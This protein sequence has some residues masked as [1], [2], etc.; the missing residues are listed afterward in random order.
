MK[1]NH[2]LQTM[3]GMLAAILFLIGIVS[4]SATT[5]EAVT[6]TFASNSPPS[7]LKGDAEKIFLEELEK[8]AGGEL[9]IKPFWAESLLKGKEI[10]KGVENGIVDMGQVNIAFSW[11]RLMRNSGL[12]LTNEGPVR[13]PNK[14]KTFK[15]IYA[16]VPELNEEFNKYKQQTVYMYTLTSISTCLTKPAATI[17]DFKDLKIRSSSPFALQVLKDLGATPVSLPWGDLYISL[18]TN[19]IQ[20][21]LTNTDSIHRAKL[22]E[23]APH[24][25]IMDRIWMPIPYQININQKKWQSLSPEIKAAFAMAAENAEKR[26]SQ[27]YDQWWERIISDMKKS[28]ATVTFASDADYDR[29]AGVQAHQRNEAFWVKAVSKGGVEDAKGLLD[30]I[31]TIVAEEVKREKQ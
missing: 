22:Y 31:Q 5:A 16:E 25:F 4:V 3:A 15:R 20:G 7:G 26:F 21:V 11:K 24:M 29:W 10:L 28:G 2:P 17:D 8:A 19:A 1:K 13:Y 12:L 6:L 9:T 23:V 14:M 30:R 27:V 18:Q